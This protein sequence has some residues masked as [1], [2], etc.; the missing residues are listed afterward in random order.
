[1]SI[2]GVTLVRD[3]RGLDF[4]ITAAIRS[5]L[6]LVDEMIVNVGR[7]GDDT[8]RVLAR[9]FP[10]HPVRIVERSWDLNR[11]GSVLADETQYAV[12]Q[13]SGEWVVY[14][15]AD[16]VL[17]EDSIA[18]F[19]E[20][21]GRWQSEPL[22]EGLLVDF[23]HHYQSP[24]LVAT[25][26]HWYRRE[27][28]AFKTGV[29]VRS[30]HEAQGFRVGPEKRRVRARHSGAV[31]HH[32]GWCRPAT[33]LQRKRE[34][35]RAL[36]HGLGPPLPQVELPWEYGLRR[37]EGT[38]PE[39]IRSWLQERDGSQAALGRRRWSPRQLR[40]WGSDLWERVTGRRVWEYRNYVEV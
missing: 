13:A 16:E 15:Q 20:A 2:S 33:A 38:H 27:V 32:Y 7:I 36:Y 39:V 4:P 5:V 28:R 40:L 26:R 11:G 8:A 29:G 23:V 18:P 37:F 21:L 9:E 22:V 1:M 19:R 30:Y 12:E 17:H 31:Y 25:A 6:P 24:G 35:D 34:S 10:D 14:V 3:P